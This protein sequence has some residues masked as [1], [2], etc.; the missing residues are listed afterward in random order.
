MKRGEEPEWVEVAGAGRDDRAALIAG[1]LEA[2]GI[3]CQIE[4][5]SMTPLPENLGSFGMSRVLVPPDRAAEARE[6]IA[7]HEEADRS[8]RD[9]KGGS[10]DGSE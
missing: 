7:R 6:L 5:P 9:R 4:G 2:E 10:E 3:P 1:M 8:R